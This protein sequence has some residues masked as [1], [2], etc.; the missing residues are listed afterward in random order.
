MERLRQFLQKTVFSLHKKIEEH[1]SKI[2]LSLTL[3]ISWNYVKLLLLNGVVF[4]AVFAVLYI[5]EEKKDYTERAESM[6]IQ[7]ER[8]DKNVIDAIQRQSDMTFR[9]L[10]KDGQLLYEDACF[11]EEEQFH[12]DRNEVISLFSL[13]LFGE[14]KSLIVMKAFDTMLAGKHCEIQ[15][16]YNMTRILPNLTSLLAKLIFVYLIL[17][18]FIIF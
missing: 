16:E 3:R 18:F 10:D 5:G 7:I 6:V 9:I 4:F 12:K 11:H 13:D 8:K 14:Q 2:R 17:A 1:K 15:F